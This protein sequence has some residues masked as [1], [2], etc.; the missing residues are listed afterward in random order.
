MRVRTIRRRLKK[1]AC[2]RLAR[3]I[4]PVVLAFA[5]LYHEDDEPDA[6]SGGQRLDLSGTVGGQFEVANQSALDR[7][8]DAPGPPYRIPFGF[9]L[10][11]GP[12]GVRRTD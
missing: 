3:M 5:D 9:G 7:R 8:T 12:H 11:G 4:Y 10:P 6:D 2:Y 1:R